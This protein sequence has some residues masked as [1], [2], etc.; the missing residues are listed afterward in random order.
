M[1]WRLAHPPRQPP[2]GVRVLPL[3]SVMTSTT[4]SSGST[5]RE[6]APRPDRHTVV[7]DGECGVCRRSVELLRRWDTDDRLRLLPFQGPGVMDRFPEIT[8]REFREAVQVIAPDG[9]HWSGADAME[10]A[11]DQTPKGRRLARLFK[12]PLARPIA[13]RVYRWFARHRSKLAR[14]F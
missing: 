13:R 8:E 7:Y 9:R 3:C 5:A 4:S 2:G 14:F 12:L 11:L 1:E 6:P 10:K